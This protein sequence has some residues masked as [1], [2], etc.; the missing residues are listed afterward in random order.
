MGNSLDRPGA[1]VTGRPARGA[2]RTDT[3]APWA[4]SI[5][6]TSEGIMATMPWKATRV[7]DQPLLFIAEYLKG[8]HT[9]TELCEAFGISRKTGHKFID[10]FEELGPDGRKDMP[11]T[12]HSRPHAVTPEVKS[13][14][15]LTR[16][17][18]PRW[19]PRK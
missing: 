7:M 12:P 10:R 16:Q 18:H 15:L 17:A 9:V 6:N 13:L 5:G 14:L 11:R 3:G 19:G 1:W 2:V 8:D 4:G